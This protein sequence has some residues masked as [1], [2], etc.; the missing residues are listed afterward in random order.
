MGHSLS[1][2]G[3]DSSWGDHLMSGVDEIRHNTLR[4]LGSSRFKVSVGYVFS[5][6]LGLG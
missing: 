2:R 5:R 4:V 1:G 3:I 6:A